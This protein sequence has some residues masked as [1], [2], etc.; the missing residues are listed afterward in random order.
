MVSIYC[1]AS[2]LNLVCLLRILICLDLDI[3]ISRSGVQVLPVYP[4]VILKH[5]QAENHKSSSS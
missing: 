5:S 1:W 2:F 4:Q 3:R